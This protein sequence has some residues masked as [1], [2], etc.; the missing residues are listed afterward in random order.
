LCSIT[1][2]IKKMT[3]MVDLSDMKPNWFIGIRVILS[4]DAR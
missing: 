4:D 1:C 2:L 3:S